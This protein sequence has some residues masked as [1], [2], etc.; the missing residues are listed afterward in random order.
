MKGK[1]SNK[2]KKVPE[3]TVVKANKNSANSNDKEILKSN[4]HPKSGKG[5]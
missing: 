1:G 5:L 4:R 2:M 3:K